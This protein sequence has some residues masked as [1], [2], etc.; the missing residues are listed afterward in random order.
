MIVKYTIDVSFTYLNQA[1]MPSF[2]QRTLQYFP[3]IVVL[4]L[5]VI[6]YS[7]LNAV[8]IVRLQINYD[9]T[10]HE[11][12]IE[13]FDNEAPNTVANYLNYVNSLDLDGLPKYQDSLVTAVFPDDGRPN[14]IIQGGGYTF[15]DPNDPNVTYALIDPIDPNPVGLK[16]ITA[17]PAVNNE[18]SLSNLRG[19]IAMAK[20]PARFNEAGC[21][22]IEP[23]CTLVP[24]TGPDTATRQWFINLIDNTEF[25]TQN[26]GF[27]VF[28]KVID[29]AMN[30]ADEISLFPIRPF[31]G[32]VLNPDFSNLPVVNYD[33]VALPAV[34]EEHLII[35]RSITEINPSV[36]M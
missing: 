19:T 6:F 27:T 22:Q 31:A 36:S 2:F 10:P 32:L 30:I 14:A 15:R 12:D 11:M 5:T 21:T 9:G 4:F 3:A 25:D 20:I 1:I 23:G 28:G 7:D 16:I 26:G 35:I 13:L 33:T 34:L 24:G 8:Q 18:F 17:F 29:D